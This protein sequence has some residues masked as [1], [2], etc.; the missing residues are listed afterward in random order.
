MIDNCRTS[1]KL[2]NNLHVPKFAS[3]AKNF[4]D[5]HPNGFFTKSQFNKAILLSQLYAYIIDST[6]IK[7]RI[8]ISANQK[9]F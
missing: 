9:H 7:E 1:L 3:D 4:F 5:N 8:Y 6:N 2:L